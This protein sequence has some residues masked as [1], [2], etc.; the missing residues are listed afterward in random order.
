MAAMIE[1]GDRIK[2]PSGREGVVTWVDPKEGRLGMLFAGQDSVGMV[3]DINEVELVKKGE[4][5]KQNGQTKL[6]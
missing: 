5:R 6:L 1:K 3:Y 4:R 2:N